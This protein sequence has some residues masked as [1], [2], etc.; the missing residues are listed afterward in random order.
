[1]GPDRRVV[2]AA[3]V[4]LV[5]V[6]VAGCTGPAPPPDR[7]NWA[8][9][10]VQ[11][12]DLAA[13]GWTGRGVAVAILDTGVELEG[14]YMGGVTVTFWEDLVNGEP[15]PY[16]DNGHGTAMASIL[17]GRGDLSGGAPGVD[18]IVI[19]VIAGDGSGSDSTV[20][21]GISHA[22][23][24]GADIISLSLGG[25][26][27]PV[28][29]SAS[30]QA[31]ESAVAAGVFVV[32]SAGNDGG[33]GDD[34]QVAAPGVSKDAISVGAV[35]SAFTIAPFSSAGRSVFFPPTTDPNRK[36]EVVAP[37][38]DIEVAWTGGQ[39]ATVSG[40]SPA[41]VFVSAGLA[42]LLGAHPDLQRQDSSTVT[43]VKQAI[44]DSAMAVGGQQT[45]HD[46]HYGYGLFRAAAAEALL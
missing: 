8:F 10:A 5:V 43:E 21:A 32:A 23:S 2:A 19:K 4:L 25:G 38:V 15:D 29:G 31:A 7:S 39:A 36:P 26:S 12:S 34:G 30:T 33:A 41:A 27:L 3:A 17:V 46:N 37:G 42:L 6:S 45:P 9:D 44:M 24:A 40:T 13:A 35:D 20:A 28:L 1:M 22:V 18:L 11:V 14:P 16:D